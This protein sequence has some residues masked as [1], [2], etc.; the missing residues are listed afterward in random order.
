MKANGGKPL[1]RRQSMSNVHHIVNV[2]HSAVEEGDLTQVKVLLRYAN[3][4]IHLEEH[5]R[6][7]RTALQECVLR[8]DL[9]MIR[10][11]LDNGASLEATDTYGWTTLHYAAFF[12]SLDVVRFL[13][14]NCANLTALNNNGETPLDICDDPEVRFYLQ[15]MLAL[16]KDDFSDEDYEDDDDVDEGFLE[17]KSWRHESDNDSI[18]NSIGSKTLDETDYSDLHDTTDTDFDRYSPPPSPVKLNSPEQHDVYNQN[19]KPGHLYRTTLTIRQPE[20][21]LD[22]VKEDASTATLTTRQP[23]RRLET[24]KEDISTLKPSPVVQEQV[25]PISKIPSPRSPTRSGIPRLK[26]KTTFKS[27]IAVPI[28]RHDRPKSLVRDMDIDKKFLNESNHKNN[29]TDTKRPLRDPDKLQERFKRLSLHRA[30]SETDISSLKDDSAFKK[31]R[32]RRM[33]NTDQLNVLGVFK[34]K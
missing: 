25:Q 5:N 30:A 8:D 27:Q 12:G 31:T 26:S 19:K 32:M 20:R 15:G 34:G 21:H 18:G 22:T 13:V 3:T 1:R 28:K 10:Y 16:R 14:L 24:V 7:G 2:F 23:E 17:G 4:N 11:L 29:E 9:E 6:N 33:S